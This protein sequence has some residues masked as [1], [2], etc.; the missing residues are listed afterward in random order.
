MSRIAV[1]VRASKDVTE[2]PRDWVPES[3]GSRAEVA[4][5]ICAAASKNIDITGER[6]SL[7]S[8][9]LA[10]ELEV[11]EGVSPRS[12]TVSGTFGC[13]EIDFL[14]ALCV[15]LS[16]RLYDAESGAFEL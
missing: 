6:A 10:L 4:S 9:G 5:A 8:S 11:E 15:L 16:A 2:L 1:V 7:Y 3:L 14:R 12:I 13:S